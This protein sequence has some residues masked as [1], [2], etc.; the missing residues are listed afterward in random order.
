MR[1]KRKDEWFFNAHT[2]KKPCVWHASPI[3]LMIWEGLEPLKPSRSISGK[4]VSDLS[5]SWRFGRS[6][7]GRM[8]RAGTWLV[9]ATRS[10]SSRGCSSD[11]AMDW[12][13][14]ENHAWYLGHIYRCI[15]FM[16]TETH[17]IEITQSSK[18][19]ESVKH[20]P[21]QSCKT[22]AAGQTIS[23]RFTSYP[24]IQMS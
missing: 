13:W 21:I 12:V 1:S 6:D 14:D 23:H 18:I 4:M 5:T 11:I 2:R 10:V 9:W 8:K 7:M 19:E 20:L 16:M 17:T 22:G 15:G 24:P 3:S